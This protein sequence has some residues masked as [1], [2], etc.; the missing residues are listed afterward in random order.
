MT[1]F[2]FEQ[3]AALLVEGSRE[4]MGLGYDSLIRIARQAD[5]LVNI[6]GALVDAALLECIPVRLY[7]DLDP[8]FT[9]LWHFAQGIDLRLAGHTHFAT[10][11]LAI[12]Q[13]ECTVPTGGL[14][15]LRT[16][17]PVVLEHWTVDDNITL[18][19]LTTVANWRGYGSIEHDGVHY[20]QKAHSL[21][22]LIDL[23]T[24]VEDRFV[25]ALAIHPRETDD[26]ERLTHHRW[27]LV[28]PQSVAGT[29]ATY[30]AFVRG[31]RAEVGVA[32]SGYVVSRSGWFSD[33]SACYLASGR[34]VIAQDTGFSHWLPTGQGLLCFDTTEQAQAAIKDMNGAY[35]RHARAARGLAE[36]WLDSDKVLAS[37]LEQLAAAP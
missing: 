29:P 17:P 20:G 13:S 36:G 10:V 25:L 37:L 31:S 7:L 3:S 18:D 30:R 4:C 21:R 2:G 19:A 16:L 22:K 12:G 32:K 33:R 34:P 28:D 23:P 6:S 35:A 14:Q 9:Q 1:E 24:R 8:A 26:L 27:E 5:V 15:W 11:G